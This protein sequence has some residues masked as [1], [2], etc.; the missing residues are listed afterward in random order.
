MIT[1][2]HDGKVG[3]FWMVGDHLVAAGCHVKEAEITED[4]A[5]YP[6]GHADYWDRWREAGRGWLVRH[7]LPL[8][9]LSSEYDEHPRGRIVFERRSHC[10]LLYA[11]RRLHTVHR[12]SSIRKAF[13]LGH[14]VKIFR[15][16][17]YR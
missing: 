4:W 5:D 16:P 13:E 9:I 11:D 8:E 12:L 2:E 15:D 10:F 6:G 1:P 7:G 17:H 3:I 14:N